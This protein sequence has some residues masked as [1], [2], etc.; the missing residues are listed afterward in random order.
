MGGSRP[1]SP[2]CYG[3]PMF[4]IGPYEMLIILALGLMLFSPR[5]LP[6]VLKGIARFWGSIRRTADEFRDAIMQDEE[7]G[8]L[9]DAYQGTADELRGAELQA[10]R[11]LTK[12]R[13]EVR[14]AESKLT[15]VAKA[16]GD[17]EDAMK[18]TVAAAQNPDAW[19]GSADRVGSDSSQPEPSAPAA[20][21]KPPASPPPPATGAA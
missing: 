1:P 12:A 3:F 21:K 10:R 9:R 18:D 15:G 17:A 13:M 4:G 5:E 7:L 6:G 19:S 11:E 14:R 2:L 20:S 16:A 8:E